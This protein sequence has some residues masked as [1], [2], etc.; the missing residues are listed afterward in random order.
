M[1]LSCPNSGG[2]DWYVN[3]HWEGLPYLQ[4]E[5]VDALECL[6]CHQSFDIK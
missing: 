2:F 4:S 3:T 6:E 1:E 5:V